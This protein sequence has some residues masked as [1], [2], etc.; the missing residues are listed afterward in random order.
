MSRRLM[1]AGH[2]CVIFDANAK[3]R[4]ALAKEGATAVTSLEDVVKAL[5]DKP[6]AV[7]EDELKSFYAAAR[8]DPGRPL[9]D[10]NLLGLGTDG[11]T[12]SL[13]PDDAVLVE[14]NK[15]VAAVVGVKTEARITLTYPV[16]ESSRNA[17]FL[18][19]GAEKRA[20]FK[21][22]LLGDDSLPAARIHPSGTLWT[23]ADAGAVG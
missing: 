22:L 12:A 4:E 18:V 23:F 16:L 19:V 15:W 9:F 10:V 20:I 8:L 6:R 3:P 14:R 7:Y 5:K 11:H 2:T 17:V 1:R 21:R 13:F